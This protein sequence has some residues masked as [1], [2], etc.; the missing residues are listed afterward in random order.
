MS[1]FTRLSCVNILHII[2]FDYTQH[3]HE[4]SLWG[5]SKLKLPIFLLGVD[6]LLEGF[7]GPHS[8]IWDLKSSTQMQSLIFRGVTLA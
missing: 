2:Q 3:R 1:L 7:Q 6:C 5:E 8:T 4:V